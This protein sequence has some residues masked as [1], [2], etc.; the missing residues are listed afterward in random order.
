MQAARTGVPL[1][2]LQIRSHFRRALIA[3]LPVFLQSL[4]DDPF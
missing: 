4:V 2:P 1:Q 3:Q